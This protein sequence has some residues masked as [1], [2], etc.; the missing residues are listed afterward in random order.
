MAALPTSRP[1]PGELKAISPRCS[2]CAHGGIYGGVCG[3]C[4][5]CQ[6]CDEFDQ[7]CCCD[8]PAAERFDEALKRSE[9]YA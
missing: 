1:H 8:V 5:L 9:R 7:D 3:R 6:V 2:Y 4:G